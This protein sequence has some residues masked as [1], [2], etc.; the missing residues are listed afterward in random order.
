MLVSTMLSQS[1]KLAVWAGPI[2]SASPALLISISIA[3]NSAD[4][5]ANAL[6]YSGPVTGIQGQWQTLIEL[7]L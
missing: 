4:R 2:P 5:L 7:L 3:E 1:S 6:L